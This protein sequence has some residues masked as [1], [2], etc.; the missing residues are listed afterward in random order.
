M[1][2][3][4]ARIKKLSWSADESAPG[5]CSCQI[6]QYV[7]N[8]VTCYWSRMS[9]PGS[10][11]VSLHHSCVSWGFKTW[12]SLFWNSLNSYPTCSLHARQASRYGLGLGVFRI[13]SNWCTCGLDFNVDLGMIY[14]SI[15]AGHTFDGQSSK[16]PHCLS[17][18]SPYDVLEFNQR[19]GDTHDPRPF[20]QNSPLCW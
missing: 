8:L 16:W 13:R 2:N 10:I 1:Y 18:V 19:V 11:C 15:D 14:L 17:R 6:I 3:Q 20:L 9:M 12:D 7:N 5:I 4:Q